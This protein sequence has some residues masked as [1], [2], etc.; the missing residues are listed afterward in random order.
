MEKK[1]HAIISFEG[2]DCS[3]KETNYKY[4]TSKLRQMR[5][6]DYFKIHKEELKKYL[7]KKSK[8]I[9]KKNQKIFIINSEK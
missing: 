9:C 6:E 2:L 1:N 4:Y 7:L 5:G 8:N 3:F